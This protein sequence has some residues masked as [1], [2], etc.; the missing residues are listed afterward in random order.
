[1]TAK[2]VLSPNKPIEVLIT[3]INTLTEL[4]SNQSFIST[5]KPNDWSHGNLIGQ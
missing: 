3:L 1:M 2:P 5:L 4:L